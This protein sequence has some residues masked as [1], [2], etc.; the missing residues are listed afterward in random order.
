MNEKVCGIIKFPIDND[1]DYETLMAIIA[2]DVFCIDYACPEARKLY[3]SLTTKQKNEIKKYVE[4]RK[5]G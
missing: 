4:E 3:Y 1:R 2:P 5:K